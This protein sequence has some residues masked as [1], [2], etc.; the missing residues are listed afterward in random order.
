MCV[1]SCCRREAQRERLRKLL[2]KV[3]E[4]DGGWNDRVFPRS[5]NFGTAMTIFALLA[6][7]AHAPAGWSAA[8]SQDPK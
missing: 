6:P 3:R 8:K 7:T 2:W 5:E 1:W 4:Q